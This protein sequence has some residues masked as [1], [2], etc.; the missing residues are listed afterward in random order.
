MTQQEIS[1]T[2]REWATDNSHTTVDKGNV[3]NAGNVGHGNEKVGD[4]RWFHDSC[5]MLGE[6]EGVRVQH[7]GLT[8]R[9]LSVYTTF[10]HSRYRRHEKTKYFG[11]KTNRKCT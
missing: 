2:E 3:W 1:S 9:D 5:A 11:F 8:V 7:S 6:S 10:I 4:A